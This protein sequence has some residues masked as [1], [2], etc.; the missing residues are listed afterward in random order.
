MQIELAS[1]LDTAFPSVIKLCS[2]NSELKPDEIWWTVWWTIRLFT[3]SEAEKTVY[4]QGTERWQ[5]GRMRRSRKP[6]YGNPVPRVRIPPS[7]PSLKKTFPEY[8][9]TIELVRCFATVF[10][11]G[12]AHDF[13]SPASIFWFFCWKAIFPDKALHFWEWGAEP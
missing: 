9:C 8:F 2:N 6:L 13:A 4:L 10:D 11:R 12:F 3:W 1:Q 7:P 5:S